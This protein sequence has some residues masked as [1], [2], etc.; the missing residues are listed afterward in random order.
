MKP[1]IVE[2]TYNAPIEKVW[3]ALTDVAE[4]K[5]WYFQLEDF[6]PRVGFKFD[7]L[8]GEVGGPQ[9]LHLCEVTQVEDG[10]K[11]A[12]TWRYDNYTGNSE[13][14]WE[15]KDKGEQTILKLI[16][17]GIE[18]M[19]ENGPMFQRDSFNG[20]WNHFVHTAL[21]EYLGA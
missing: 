18:T 13:V 10:K 6:Q 3:Q 20:G 9:F 14:S 11:I 5:K 17:T 2:R 8:A 4:L 12:Y 16:H 1:L 21:K 7:F 19:A 15:L